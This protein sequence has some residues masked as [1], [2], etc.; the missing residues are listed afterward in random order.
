MQTGQQIRPLFGCWWPHHS[1]DICR[2]NNSTAG[3]SGL[4]EYSPTTYVFVYMCL[5][6][7]WLD[8]PSAFHLI[9]AFEK[10]CMAL[11]LTD[12]AEA[13]GK[14]Y[15]IHKPFQRY[16]MS[17]CPVKSCLMIFLLFLFMC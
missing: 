3:S 14:V 7:P 8:G 16:F 1:P 17:S 6:K 4:H 12:N 13:G 5:S 10:T 9:S 15:T 11:Q 2:I